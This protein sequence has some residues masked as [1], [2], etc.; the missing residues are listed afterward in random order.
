MGGYSSE[1]NISIKSGEVVY[2]T[3]SEEKD[4]NLYKV[5]MFYIQ[6]AGIL[7]VCQQKM[8]LDRII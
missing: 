6:W 3:L 7:L 1:Y 2:K 4:I 8:P 5:L